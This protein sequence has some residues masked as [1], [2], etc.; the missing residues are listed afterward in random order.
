V[1]RQINSTRAN[2]GR[3][4]LTL[5]VY[6]AKKAQRWAQYLAQIGRLKHSSLS[7]GVP[8]RWRSLAENVGYGSTLTGV[9]AAFLRSSGHR[10]NILGNFT[11][12]GTGVARSGSRVYVVHVFMRI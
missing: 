6:L 8:Y 10:A 9:H 1:H 2:Y 5:N 7:S 12:V 4:G 3:R 11:H